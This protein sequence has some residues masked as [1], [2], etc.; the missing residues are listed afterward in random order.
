MTLIVEDGTGLE[1]AE[2]YASAAEA[3]DYFSMRGDTVWSALG[4]S[5]KEQH[6]RLATDYIESLYLGDWQ[7]ERVSQVQR[8]AWPRYGVVRDGY[9]LDAAPL[10]RELKEACFESAVASASGTLVTNAVEAG[11]SGLVE[12][13][14]VRIGTLLTRTK[15]VG[16]R[17]AFARQFPA[18]ASRLDALTGGGNQMER[19]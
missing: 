19:M 11:S 5:V 13:E 12:E 6:L 17:S 15:Y 14:E 10:P 7:G 16:G 18:T 9:V 4:P 2:A 8:L 3:D 1:T